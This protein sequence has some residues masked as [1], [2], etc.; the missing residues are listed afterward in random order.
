[1]VGFSKT[2]VETKKS[3]FSCFFLRKPKE[4]NREIQGWRKRKRK[5]RNSGSLLNIGHF[6]LHIC[7]SHKIPRCSS[8]RRIFHFA[9]MSLGY[10]EKLS[11]REDVGSVG[12]S[13]IFDPPEVLQKKVNAT[14]FDSICYFSVH[15]ILE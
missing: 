7:P 12:M 11:Y 1:M 10:A 13:E 14:F 2:Q 4:K 6:H 8:V 5:G 9:N 15:C 3:F